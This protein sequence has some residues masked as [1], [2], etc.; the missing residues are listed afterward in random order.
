VNKMRNKDSER[1]NTKARP[2]LIASGAVIAVLPV[3]IAILLTP[4]GGNPLSECGT[5]EGS[6]GAVAIWFTLFT[7]PIGVCLVIIGFGS[8][9]AT[10]LG[11][12]ILKRTIFYPVYLAIRELL[13]KSNNQKP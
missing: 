8:Q 10:S 11:L 9:S 2:W 4:P 12:K 6:G 7:I 13:S 1:S 3:I 5:C